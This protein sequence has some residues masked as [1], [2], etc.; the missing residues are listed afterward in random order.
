MPVSPACAGLIFYPP[1]VIEIR[2][3]DETGLLIAFATMTGFKA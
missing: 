2:V 1:Y 3:T